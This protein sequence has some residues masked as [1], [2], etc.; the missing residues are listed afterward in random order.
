MESSTSE[1]FKQKQHKRSQFI[2]TATDHGDSGLKY[3]T[4]L[5]QLPEYYTLF[6][7]KKKTVLCLKS[8]S[9]QLDDDL[10]SRSQTHSSL[11]HISVF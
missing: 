1:R 7:H 8:D 5:V 10:F 6:N 9:L 4:A 2:N 11:T 3:L